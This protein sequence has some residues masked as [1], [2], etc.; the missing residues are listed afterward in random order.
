MKVK[1]PQRVML[2][3][4]WAFICLPAW[5]DNVEPGSDSQAPKRQIASISGARS[6]IKTAEWH[7]LAP[8]APN[9]RWQF[10][11]ATHTL[12]FAL[13][14]PA[15]VEEG[16]SCL[17]KLSA[18][19]VPEGKQYFFQAEHYLQ[20]FSRQLNSLPL[21]TPVNDGSWQLAKGKKPSTM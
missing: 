11:Q 1:L 4:V 2:S 21:V 9:W 8:I 5:A 20:T 3:C 18:Q 17:S 10:N 15:S 12:N 19:I 16:I 13:R 7:D 14:L 6:K